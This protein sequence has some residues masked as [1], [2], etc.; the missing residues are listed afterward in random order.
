MFKQT[1]TLPSPTPSAAL[2]SSSL[3]LSLSLSASPSFRLPFC[4]SLRRPLA[5]CF[6]SRCFPGDGHYHALRLGWKLGL[7]DGPVSSKY[8]GIFIILCNFHCIRFLRLSGCRGLS[9]PLSRFDLPPSV[10]P[11]D[12]IGPFIAA[13]FKELRREGRGERD[14]SRYSRLSAL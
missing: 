11:L 10:Q 2:S 4:A 5:F 12:A 6:S 1:R 8:R 7:L 14:I 3:L 13:V 9:L